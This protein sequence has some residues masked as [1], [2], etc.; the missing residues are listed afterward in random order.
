MLPRNKKE[1][2]RMWSISLFSAGFYIIGVEMFTMCT[3][4][5]G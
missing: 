4:S 2:V 5:I 3:R 1:R